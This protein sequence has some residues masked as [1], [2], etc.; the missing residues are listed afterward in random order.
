MH[1]LGYTK[2]V[3]YWSYFCTKIM[4]EILF[5]LMFEQMHQFSSKHFNHQD[6][7][8][9][10]DSTYI[11]CIVGLSTGVYIRNLLKRAVILHKMLFFLEV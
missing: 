9:N 2:V 6:S 3:K 11:L 7:L 10:Y 4:L 5:D 1:C 8:K